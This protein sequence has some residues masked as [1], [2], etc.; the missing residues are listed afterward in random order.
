MIRYP[1]TT[2]AKGSFLCWLLAV[3][4]VLLPG[5]STQKRYN[6]QVS[7]ARNLTACC[8][9]GDSDCAPEP[10]A[11]DAGGCSSSEEQELA[12]DCKCCDITFERLG[13]ELATAP[14]LPAT[15]GPGLQPALLPTPRAPEAPAVSLRGWVRENVP[16]GPGAGRPVY[17]LNRSLLI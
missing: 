3:L 17:L 12:A 5:T 7:G 4:V 9:T 16:R 14:Q 1:R 15:G 13:S 2:S 10:S 8:C 11:C 6:C